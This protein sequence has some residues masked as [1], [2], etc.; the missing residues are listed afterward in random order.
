MGVKYPSPVN[1]A[2]LLLLDQ[3]AALGSSSRLRGAPKDALRADR[4][5]PGP[6]KCA[7]KQVRWEVPVQ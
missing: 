7:G 3:F 5:R 6:C 2:S 1:G 4:S